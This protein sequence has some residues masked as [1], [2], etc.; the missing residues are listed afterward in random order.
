VAYNPKDWYWIVAGSTTQ[1]F[2]SARQ[3]YVPV[4]DATYLAWRELNFP[5]QIISEAEL[6]AV[7]EQQAPGVVLPSNAGLIGYAIGKQ[8]AIAAGGISVAISSSVT[9]EASTDTA[10]LALLS[11][12]V[13]VAQSNPSATTPWVQKN[14]TPVS[15][16]AGEVL[17]ILAAVSAFIQSTFATLSA[18][19]AAIN[20]GTITTRN[21][22]DV[23][24]S[25]PAW[26]VNS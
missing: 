18:V 5:T 24:P 13:A 26:P 14:G 16:N 17:E 1:V 3:A 20:G 4:T 7:L 9:I 15:L 22:V 2:S 8:Q 19:I 23:P 25:G 12:A 10:S 21:Q 6:I 11:T